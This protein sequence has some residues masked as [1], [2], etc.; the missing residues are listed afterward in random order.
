MIETFFLLMCAHAL[1]DFQLQNGAMHIRKKPGTE[2]WHYWMAAHALIAGGAVYVV[3]GSAFL[4]IAETV[5]HFI[6]D[7]WKS[8][9]RI[10]FNTDQLLHVLFRVVYAIALTQ[11]P[12]C[13]IL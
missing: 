10:G 5:A 12:S 9:N 11:I 2:H 1:C 4:G 3:T 8:N 13:A 6:I 7:T